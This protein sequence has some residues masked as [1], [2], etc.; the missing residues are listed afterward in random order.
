MISG[1]NYL[2][3]DFLGT[4]KPFCSYLTNVWT[5]ISACITQGYSCSS[6]GFYR[7]LPFSRSVFPANSLQRRS[8]AD[9]SVSCIRNVSGVWSVWKV[10][11]LV[12]CGASRRLSFPGFARFDV[13]SGSFSWQSE[14]YIS[15]SADKL[16]QIMSE[17]VSESDSTP[18]SDIC[19]NSHTCCCF[20]PHHHIETLN[21]ASRFVFA[22]GQTTCGRF[23][24]RQRWKAAGQL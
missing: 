2:L 9:L 11:Q 5:R 24:K 21:V 14:Q 8:L 13:R 19:I 6:W 18:L 15:G 22:G 3:N 23:L 20:A 10:W 7:S 17:F 16:L 1:A 12:I 4:H